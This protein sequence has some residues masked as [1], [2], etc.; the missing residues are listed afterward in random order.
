V[1][2]VYALLGDRPRRGPGAGIRREPLRILGCAGVFAVVGRMTTPPPLDTASVRGH[3]VTV[4]RLAR[5]V[6]AILPARFG[7][8]LADEDALAEVLEPRIGELREA[9]AVVTGREQMTL[10]V[11]GTPSVPAPLPGSEEEMSLGPGARYLVGRAGARKQAVPEIEPIRPLLRG[12]V[13]GERV[14]R[15]DAPP[16]IASVY[17]LV[18]RGQSRR[19]RA[20]LARAAPALVATRLTVSGP[21]APY[22]FV[23]EALG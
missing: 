19:Y 7:S 3:A 8:T 17:H 5:S 11:Y 22:A 18:A 23:P 10:R 16:L 12:L 6:D 9:L 13:H 14:A 15:H 20:R 2:Y 1:L 4:R 21:W